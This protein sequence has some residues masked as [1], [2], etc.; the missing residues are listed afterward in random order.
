M[1]QV[2]VRVGGNSVLSG[3][4]ERGLGE[5]STG[6]DAGVDQVNRGA[7]PAGVLFG[8]CPVS[9]VHSAVAG[10]NARMHIDDRAARRCQHPRGDDARSV[11][12]DDVRLNRAEQRHY[13]FVVD[14]ANPE[15]RSSGRRVQRRSTEYGVPSPHSMPQ[16]DRLEQ[17]HKKDL[18]DDGGPSDSSCPSSGHF[19]AWLPILQDDDKVGHPGGDIVG[20]D[21]RGMPG[22]R[23]K[24]HLGAAVAWL[25]RGVSPPWLRVSAQCVS[26]NHATVARSPSGSAVGWTSGNMAD[27]RVGSACE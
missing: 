20:H 14:R 7:D 9:P 12:H 4:F 22:A 1:H 26:R 15:G 8:E 27:K 16:E 3:Y 24:H 5:D 19:H 25:R 11:H 23:Q 17:G 2:Q 18:A 6:I 10:R 21:V 13:P